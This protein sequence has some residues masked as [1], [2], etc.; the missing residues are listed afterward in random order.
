MTVFLMLHPLTQVSNWSICIGVEMRQHSGRS[1][2]LFLENLE[3][4]FLV[5]QMFYFKWVDSI[6]LRN[7]WQEQ[8]KRIVAGKQLKALLVHSTHLFSSLFSFS[9]VFFFHSHLFKIWLMLDFPGWIRLLPIKTIDADFH[10]GA[11]ISN[12]LLI[13]NLIQLQMAVTKGINFSRGYCKVEWGLDSLNQAKRLFSI[14]DSQ[15]SLSLPANFI[16]LNSW[17]YS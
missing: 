14:F 13:S 5:L 7:L 10:Q 9:E 12:K 8:L 6:H 11:I 4:I 1:A 17:P 16:H 2:G 15:T 3:A